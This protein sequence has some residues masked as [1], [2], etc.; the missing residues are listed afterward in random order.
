[1]DFPI[2][3]EHITKGELYSRYNTN[4]RN[5]GLECQIPDLENDSV[6][7]TTSKKNHHE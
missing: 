6:H 5:I 3:M 1:M 2:G 7:I 4:R